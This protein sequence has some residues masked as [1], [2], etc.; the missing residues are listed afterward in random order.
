MLVITKII[1]KF[2][3]DGPIAILAFFF[4]CNSPRIRFACHL[5]L[6]GS[7]AQLLNGST[8]QRLNCSSAVPTI[9]RASGKAHFR[10]IRETHVI[11]LIAFR[12]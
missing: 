6:N 11:D 12:I 7:T 1:N 5:L 9:R 4:A 3:F 2:L 10:T 8:A